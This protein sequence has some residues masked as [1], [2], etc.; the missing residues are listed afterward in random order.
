MEHHNT[1]TGR[2][3]VKCTLCDETFRRYSNMV[4]HR[5][6]HH[7]NKRAKVRDFVCQCGAVF[8]S[9]AKL[10]W[11]QETHDGKPKACSYCSD[12][13]V[14]ASSLTRHVRRTHNEYFLPDKGKTGALAQNVPCPVCKQVYLR[15][16]L[17][18]HLLTHSGQRP[19]SCVVCNKSFTTK[20]NLKLHRWTHAARSAK[21]FRCTLCSGAFVRRAEFVAHMH[22][23]RA[24]RPYTC[25]I[26]GCQF[27]RKYNCQRHVREH[28]AAKRFVCKV[29]D[30]GK[31]FHRSY[32]LS[33]HM[34]VH[35]GARPFAC[36]VCGKTSS[37]KSNHNKHVKIHHAREPVATEA[38]L[39]SVT[40]KQNK[41]TTIYQIKNL[42]F[43]MLG[44]KNYLWTKY[45]YH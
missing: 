10:Q 44:Y 9:R 11:H 3:P 15:S 12:K 7:F 35:S 34:K 36:T 1:H 19:H 41:F 27:I 17:R 23:H 42:A 14:H 13:F 38:W 16:N 24:Q 37:N 26:C 43:D 40:I 2:Q 32:Y 5:D 33:E 6:R 8:H 30:C 31:A 28:D 25:N 21:P 22:A 4:Q 29:P 45:D 20:W 18:A 39:Y